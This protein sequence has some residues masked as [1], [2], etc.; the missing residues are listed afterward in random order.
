[1]LKWITFASFRDSFEA[2]TRP[3]RQMMMKRR[4]EF[5]IECEGFSDTQLF[6]ASDNAYVLYAVSIFYALLHMNHVN[7]SK[8]FR[9]LKIVNVNLKNSGK[10]FK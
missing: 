9:V 6:L 3:E 7:L 5:V 8:H 4:I 10:H 2:R 1:V